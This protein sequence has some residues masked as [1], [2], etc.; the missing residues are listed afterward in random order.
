MNKT[1][2]LFTT[3]SRQWR[4]CVAQD[5]RTIAEQVIAAE[6]AERAASR[7]ARAAGAVFTNWV[8]SDRD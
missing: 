3:W 4:D 5:T 6:R 1:T 8:I 2:P 7:A